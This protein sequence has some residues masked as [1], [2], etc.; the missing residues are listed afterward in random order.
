MPTDSNSNII[1]NRLLCSDTASFRVGFLA[2]AVTANV[3]LLQGS[4]FG[5][6]AEDQLQAVL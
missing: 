1:I 6:I 2:L 4:L 5:H 3:D